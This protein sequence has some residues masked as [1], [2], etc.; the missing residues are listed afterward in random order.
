MNKGHNDHAQYLTALETWN[1]TVQVIGHYI[2][3]FQRIEEY[4]SKCISALI[5]DDEVLGAIVTSEMS[6]RAKLGVFG[7]LALYKL[8]KEELP[9]DITKVIS[10]AHSA[11][12]R[13]NTIVHSNWDA[14]I[15]KPFTAQRWKLAAKSK[16]GFIQQFEQ[17]D[18][19][20]LEADIK[21]FENISEDLL[22]VFQE[23]FE[24]E[25]YIF[26]DC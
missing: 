23:H 21:E 1:Q 25:S 24:L 12:Q 26:E 2:V 20:D 5:S 6:F 8:E 14:S 16:K 15:E 18:P 7:S 13:R 11:E 3:T 22:Y 10:R 9:E 19:E 17:V 4:L